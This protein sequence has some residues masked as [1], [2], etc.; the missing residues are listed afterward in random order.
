MLYGIV[1]YHN[2]KMFF[3]KKVKFVNYFFVHKFYFKLF[4]NNIKYF[5]TKNLN[6]T[7]IIILI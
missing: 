4:Y 6:N 5:N 2:K 7:V 3:K 1:I